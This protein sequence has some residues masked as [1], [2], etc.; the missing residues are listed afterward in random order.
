MAAMDANLGY[1]CAKWRS[2][3]AAIAL[4]LA[5]CYCFG[6]LDNWIFDCM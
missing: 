2:F 1:S 4:Y 3:S 6:L 5:R